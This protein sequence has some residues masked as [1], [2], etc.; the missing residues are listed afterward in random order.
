MSNIDQLLS[1]IDAAFT[2]SKD[3]IAAFQER[4]TQAHRDREQRLEKFE[5]LLGSLQSIWKPRLEVFTQRF[6]EKV[7]VTP[8]VSRRRREARF[9][10]NSELAHIDLRFSVFTDGD[11]RNVV[12]HYDLQILPILMTF[13]SHSEIEFPLDSVDNDAL[14]RWIDDRL[15]SFVNT[16]LSLHE[17]RYYLKGHMVVDP[18]S[19]VQF[20]K[21]AA[22]A[23]A[24]L[25]G[26]TYYFVS[27]ETC[28]E[29][30]EKR[31]VASGG[32]H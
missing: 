4:Q 5:L 10:F 3:K 25:D 30:A 26:K 12:F 19:N 28:R 11:V 7:N 14:A 8:S 32:A 24:E 21:F 20:P 9:S 22:G 18:I 23:V 15:V 13:D 27:E 31:G 1:R 17:N 16:Y 29:F 6:G 2:A